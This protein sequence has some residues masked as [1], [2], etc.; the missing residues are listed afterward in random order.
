MKNLKKLLA[1]VVACVMV[2]GMVASAAVIDFPDVAVTAKYA[3][4]VKVL[5]ALNIIN[6]DE[7]GN[8]NPDKNVTRAEMAK[9]LC[10]MMSKN[11]S[12]GQTDSG[13]ADVTAAHWASGYVKHAKG[14][15]YI[16]GYDA[17]TFGP[18]DNVTYEQAIK[19]IVA[20]LGY[21]LAADANGGYPAG[22]MMIAADKNITKNVVIADATAPAK[23]S[24][25]ALLAFNALEVGMMERETY[26]TTA[27]YKEGSKTLLADKL[28]AKKAE[29]V[30][31]ATYVEDPANYDVE[32]AEIRFDPK[33]DAEAYTRPCTDI[34]APKYLGYKDVTAYLAE[35]EDGKEEIIAVTVKATNVT[36]YVFEDLDVLADEDDL[37]GDEMSIGNQGG[38]NTE[39]AVAGQ[40]TYWTSAEHDDKK[41]TVLD[42]EAGAA[43]YVNGV[44]ADFTEANLIPQ[45]GT[46]VAYDT[47]DNDKIDLFVVEKY[48]IAVV[49]SVVA[50]SMKVRFKP[51][52]DLYVKSDFVE[53]QYALN[54][55]EAEFLKNITVTIDGEAAELADL[56][57]F[58]VAYIRTNDFADEAG[59]TFI[60][61]IVSRKTVEG[62][63]MSAI[64][65]GVI[66]IGAEDYD[67]YPTIDIRL[68][69]EG[70]YFLTVD[71]MIVGRDTEVA[72]ND[73]YGYVYKIGNS[74]F[75]DKSV[76]LFTAEGEDVTYDVSD[77]IEINEVHPA[78]RKASEAYSFVE[79]AEI[80]DVTYTEVADDEAATEANAEA[81]CAA[82]VA[83]YDTNDDDA[84]SP[85][86]IIVYLGSDAASYE[87]KLFAYEVSGDAI[88]AI[89]LTNVEDAVAEENDVL[90]AAEYTW[91]NGRFV[92]GGVGTTLASGAKIF[93][94]ADDETDI[95][96]WKVVDASALV[97]G[98]T[99]TATLYG[100]DPKADDFKAVLLN[101]SSGEYDASA[102]LAYFKSVVETVYGEDDEEAM[103]VTFIQAREEK[104]MYV[105]DEQLD[106]FDDYAIGTAFLYEVDEDANLIADAQV[107]F[108]PDAELDK[109]DV[110]DAL[111]EG[112]DFADLFDAYVDEA[113]D[114]MFTLDED[115]LDVDNEVWF[116]V[117]GAV[118]AAD[119]GL[120]LTIA[121]GANIKN[122]GYNYVVGND[123]NVVVLDY[124][125]RTVANKLVKADVDAIEASDCTVKAGKLDLTGDA[126]DMNF[127][128]ALVRLY[129]DKVVDVLV[130][131][132][133][134]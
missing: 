99:Y 86:E 106:L 133:E 91:K 116:G 59:M 104:V 19:L 22:Y 51:D 105:M 89:Y 29:G 80:F 75:G 102:A 88:T 67:V 47:N 123:A 25:I 2:F 58:D 113:N 119:G 100:Y 6:G 20:A 115:E 70:K 5:S 77:R 44:Q 15:G 93:M 8:F 63:A 85:E 72:L 84:V 60:E 41:P 9:I 46:I 96:K 14:L 66:T 114:F 128:Y 31:V 13:F 81:A 76:R 129:N 126:E 101:G 16:N 54:E 39:L 111:T 40:F 21:T 24:D 38:E 90:E 18:E 36:E 12:F 132:Y 42:I 69:S 28:G 131:N 34:T 7:T 134:N 27:E 118:S 95:A 10:A 53:N 97:A 117:I 130:I 87:E 45:V 49:D 103:K 3:E 79:L 124:T 98:R 43:V 32:D 127:K 108:T 55:D 17:A 110:I 52:A 26:G 107:I 33:G 83:K 112:E 125:K 1:L 30:I 74:A 62:K 109:D 120:A 121:A 71:G 92:Q 68:G 94:I 82:L 35:N 61:F 50:K 37:D 11:A 65:D 122:S 23:R 56:Q 57:E 73:K 78:V 64:V 48:G 4:A